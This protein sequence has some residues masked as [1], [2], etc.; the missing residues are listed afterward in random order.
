MTYISIQ[1]LDKDAAAV[2]FSFALRMCIFLKNATKTDGGRWTMDD[3]C[4]A[5]ALL[6]F[7]HWR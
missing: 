1:F 6:K 4:V 5:G 3:I 7:R 2:R